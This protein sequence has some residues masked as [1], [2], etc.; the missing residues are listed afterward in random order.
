MFMSKESKKRTTLA[1]LIM[2][3]IKEKETEIAS[4][5]SGTIRVLPVLTSA[6][7]PAASALDERIRRVYE[8]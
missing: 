4:Q 8:R 2:S 7:A 3:K 1:D 5:M 6:E